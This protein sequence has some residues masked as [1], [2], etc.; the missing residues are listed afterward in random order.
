MKARE[1][2]ELGAAELDQ[3]IR[4]RLQE[5]YDLRIKHKSGAGIEKPARLRTMRREIAR[6]KT[7]KAER[8][9]K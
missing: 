5:L 9:A 2:R 6:M 7:V 4:E 1:M 3:L 8:E